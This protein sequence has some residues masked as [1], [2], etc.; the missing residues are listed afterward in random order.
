MI[1]SWVGKLCV[2]IANSIIYCL[3]IKLV[4]FTL[5]LAFKECESHVNARTMQ[6]DT[7]FRQHNR[8]ARMSEK[9]KQKMLQSCR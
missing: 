1:I 4:S 7:V 5:F 9:P 2:Y 8:M 6:F 3:Y